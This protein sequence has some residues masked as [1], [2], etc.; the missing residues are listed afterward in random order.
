MRTCTFWF[1]TPFHF[2]VVWL[3]RFFIVTIWFTTQVVAQHLDQLLLRERL[4]AAG[5]E[6]L[7]QGGNVWKCPKP[8][9]TH[10]MWVSWVEIVY[11]RGKDLAWNAVGAVVS[12]VVWCVGSYMWAIAGS[13]RD[14][15]YWHWHLIYACITCCVFYDIVPIVDITS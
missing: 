2:Q 15:M 11:H 6:T 12:G 10:E 3:F 8:L 7:S 13:K 9:P 14:G 4:S 1:T 5:G